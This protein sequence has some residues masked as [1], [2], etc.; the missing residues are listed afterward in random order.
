M[1]NETMNSMALGCAYGGRE[2]EKEREWE[3][4]EK[5][6]VEEYKKIVSQ[7]SL[8]GTALWTRWERESRRK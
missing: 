1:V 2:E 4:D 5:K 7:M 6:K 3:R 8:C